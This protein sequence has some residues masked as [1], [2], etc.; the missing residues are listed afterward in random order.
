MKSNG[1]SHT[2]IGTLD[3][4]M[5]TWNY[6]ETKQHYSVVFESWKLEKLLDS[7]I[8]MKDKRGQFMKIF[9]G[10]DAMKYTKDGIL[11]IPEGFTDL[12]ADFA[13]FV[14]REDLPKVHTVAISKTVEQSVHQQ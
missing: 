12:D 3:I 10:A 5:L 11:E 13:Y 14:V 9:S 2:N 1:R 8:L 6:G 7:G 4:S